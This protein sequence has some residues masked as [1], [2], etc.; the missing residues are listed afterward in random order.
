M[1]PA[2]PKPKNK[3]TLRLKSSK[4]I[5]DDDLNMDSIDLTPLYEGLLNY[6]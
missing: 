2:R 5:F 1:L 4:S 3:K 6:D